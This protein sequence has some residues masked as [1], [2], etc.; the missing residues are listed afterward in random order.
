MALDY[1]YPFSSPNPQTFDAA[2]AVGLVDPGSAYSLTGVPGVQPRTVEDRDHD[3]LN[4]REFMTTA[5][6]ADVAAGTLSLD[7]SPALQAAISYCGPIGQ[8][9]VLPVGKL[10][11]DSGV[12]YSTSGYAPGLRLCGQ[13]ILGTI[14]V[15]TF[16]NGV[17]FDLF[18]AGT[19]AQFQLDTQ[20]GAFSV[21]PATE[22]PGV[23]CFRFVGL[24]GGMF[25]RLRIQFMGAHGF[26]MPWRGDLFGGSANPDPWSTTSLT[27]RDTE[28]SFCGGRGV[29]QEN[30]LGGTALYAL[31]NYVGGNRMGGYL[32]SGHQQRIHYGS[33]F[34]NGQDD[35]IFGGGVLICRRLGPILT[36]AVLSSTTTTR[37]MSGRRRRMVAHSSARG[38][39]T[40]R[41]SLLMVSIVHLWGFA[42]EVVSL[43][44]LL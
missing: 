30:G 24:R 21:A 15:P 44:L 35:P 32:L 27:I 12:T 40:G 2:L 13:G 33:C 28:I 25:Y 37:F 16:S 8:E 43:A 39:T 31:N 42:L 11:L 7:I 6:R 4:L 26:W 14:L 17:I 34:S 29:S 1:N 9:I 22:R 5:Q 10:R 36:F 18:G 20:V 19:L 41:A 3:S 38:T 23:S